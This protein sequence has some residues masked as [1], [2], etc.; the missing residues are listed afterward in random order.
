MHYGA[1]P[2][3]MTSYSQ[4]YAQQP[5]SDQR[6]A[7]HLAWQQQQYCSAVLASGEPLDSLAARLFH[8][9]PWSFPWSDE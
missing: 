6:T 2:A 8:G 4:L 9:E 7:L 3:I 1:E 5:P